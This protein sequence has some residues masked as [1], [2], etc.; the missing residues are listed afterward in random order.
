MAAVEKGGKIRLPAKCVNPSFAGDR[1]PRLAERFPAPPT[2][3]VG[4]GT[5]PAGW[6]PRTGRRPETL[7]PARCDG[8]PVR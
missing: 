2:A 4:S 7:S 3:A 8:D 5:G 6:F 1:R